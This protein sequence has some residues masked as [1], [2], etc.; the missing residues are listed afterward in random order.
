MRA[1]SAYK[2]M[3]GGLLLGASLRLRLHNYKILRG[4]K[5]LVAQAS[6]RAVK[7]SLQEMLHCNLE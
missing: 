4:R 5:I 6:V 2:A 1:R 7:D 3:G